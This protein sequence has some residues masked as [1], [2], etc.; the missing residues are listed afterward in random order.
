MN[1]Y[2]VSFILVLVFYT[3]IVVGCVMYLKDKPLTKDVKKVQ[4]RINFKIITKIEPK[5]IIKKIEKIE[6]IEIK[7]KQKR[8]KP[9]KKRPIKKR[10]IKKISKKKISKKKSKKVD[11]KEIKIKKTKST[12][13]LV[14]KVEKIKDIKTIVIEKKNEDLKKVT[15]EEYFKLIRETVN[16][17]KIYPNKARRRGIQGSVKVKFTISKD[18]FLK[19][20]NILSGKKVFYNSVKKAI[21]ESFPLIPPKDIFDQ[22]FSLEL[23]MI[24]RLH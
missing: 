17:H 18:G 24:Y 5:K 8:V 6:K 20:I 16:N 21:T 9:K 1:R 4:K 2:F 19:N 3:S 15:K 12:K 23:I 10:P 11:K 7:H 22:D 13:P 14:T